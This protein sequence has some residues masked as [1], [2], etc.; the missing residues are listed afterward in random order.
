MEVHDAAEPE[1][2]QLPG[3]QPDPLEI[4]GREGAEDQLESV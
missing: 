4:R 2:A 1:E 3:H